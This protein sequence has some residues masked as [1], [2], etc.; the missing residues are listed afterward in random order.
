MLRSSA[1]V[2]ENRRRSKPTAHQAVYHCLD[3]HVAAMHQADRTS[4]LAGRTSSLP[5]RT[6]GR[7][8]RPHRR[9]SRLVPRARLVRPG[10]APRLQTMRSD[11]LSR[12][13]RLDL[14]LGAQEIAGDSHRVSDLKRVTHPR[15][16]AAQANGTRKGRRNRSWRRAVR[17][18]LAARAAPGAFLAG[19][20]L[21]Y[22]SRPARYDFLYSLRV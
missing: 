5:S 2:G 14:D 4:D 15:P 8:L 9:F 22:T 3:W 20:H 1:L 17:D 11:C 18:G 19:R 21:A 12:R 10:R 13:R 16:H 7:A 6:P